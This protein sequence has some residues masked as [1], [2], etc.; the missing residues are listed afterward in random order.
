[1]RSR[2]VNRLETPSVEITFRGAVNLVAETVFRE[3]RLL[4]R[5]GSEE[6]TYLVLDFGFEET[7]VH[8]GLAVIET[9]GDQPEAW[10]LSGAVSVEVQRIDPETGEGLANAM[11]KTIAE[12]GGAPIAWSDWALLPVSP[13]RTEPAPADEVLVPDEVP[14]EAAVCSMCGE[15]AMFVDAAGQPLCAAHVGESPEEP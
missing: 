12:D 11:F 5:T 13:R 1:M 9:E 6:S 3:D 8:G 15:P 14:A 10:E 7:L 4:C 2:R